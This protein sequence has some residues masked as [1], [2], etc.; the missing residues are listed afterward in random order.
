MRLNMD[1]SCKK[2]LIEG[3]KNQGKNAP[4]WDYQSLV[5][6]LYT[7]LINKKCDFAIKNC[8]KHLNFTK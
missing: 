6:L 7:H 2:K 1:V 3:H 8:K 5:S 4:Q